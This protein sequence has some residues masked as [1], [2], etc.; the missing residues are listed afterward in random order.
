MRDNSGVQT[1]RAA[2]PTDQLTI[3][4]ETRDVVIKGPQGFCIDKENSQTDTDPAFVLLG[5][6]AALGRGFNLHQPTA[7]ALLTASVSNGGSEGMVANTMP[8]LDQFFRSDD[9]KAALSRSSDPESVEILDTFAQ[10]DS[11]YL[12]ANDT[13]EPIVPGAANEYWRSYFDIGDQIVAVSVIATTDQPLSPEESLNLVKSFA[14]EIR[15]ANGI[16]AEPVAEVVTASAQ[17]TTTPTSRY[18]TGTTVGNDPDYVEYDVDSQQP[19]Q[20]Q[21]RTNVLRTLQTIGLLRQLL[22]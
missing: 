20:Q 18:E 1:T 22:M 12:H 6:C 15:T 19:Q 7:R 3:N 8:A 11:Y 4:A 9:G 14:A 2:R 17:T 10:E 13:S 5:N 16:A 21:R